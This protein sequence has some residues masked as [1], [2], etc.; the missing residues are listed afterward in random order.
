M[1]YCIHCGAEIEDDAAFCP[2]CGSP[3]NSQPR[4]TNMRD[5]QDNYYGTRQVYAQSN[6]DSYDTMATFVKVFM[7][8]GCVYLAF[9]LIGLVWAIPMTT[10]A[11][12]RLDNHEPI[13]TGFK[14]CTLIF[15]SLLAGI[16]L[17]CMKDDR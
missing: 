8:I 11:W 16:I 7:V 1:K 9:T 6:D 2:K 17:L 15:V 5:G 13:G 3:C 10:Y 14:I 4:G 12:K